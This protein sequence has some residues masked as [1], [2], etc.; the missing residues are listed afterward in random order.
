MSKKVNS[1][2]KQAEELVLESEM[3]EYLLWRLESAVKLTEMTILALKEGRKDLIP[4]GL[5]DLYSRF[6][7]MLDDYCLGEDAN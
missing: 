6:Q 5:E 7:D 3:D 4:T 2:A 1:E